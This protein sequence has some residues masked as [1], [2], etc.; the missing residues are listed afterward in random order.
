MCLPGWRIWLAVS[1][2]LLQNDWQAS[3]MHAWKETIA[4][5]FC[6]QQVHTYT[7]IFHDIIM[8]NNTVVAII[9]TAIH[10]SSSSPCNVDIKN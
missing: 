4:K 3:G 9:Y 8:I 1:G 5:F 7:H 2:T 6:L 10:E